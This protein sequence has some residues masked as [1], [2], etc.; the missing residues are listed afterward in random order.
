MNNEIVTESP[1]WPDQPEM[2]F[3]MPFL[4]EVASRCGVI[5][6]IGCGHGN[7]STRAFRAGQQS[8]LHDPLLI[9]VD[10]DPNKPDVRPAGN[11]HKVTGDS[12]D[13]WVRAKTREILFRMHEEFPFPDL[14]YIDTD[15]TYEQLMA[16]LCLWEEIAAPHTVWLFHDTF[17]FGCYNTMTDAIKDFC[18]SHPQWEYVEITKESHGMGMMQWKGRENELVGADLLSR[19]KGPADL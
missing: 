19:W 5:V 4:Q 12:R 18:A 11:W 8:L 2:V 3:H 15:H 9:S 14:I 6:E 10:I 13:P 16:E 17:M 1:Q 7:G